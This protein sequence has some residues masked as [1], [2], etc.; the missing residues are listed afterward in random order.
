MAV[1]ALV[2][3][4]AEQFSFEIDTFIQKHSNAFMIV[5]AIIAAT[6]VTVDGI[7]SSGH[8]GGKQN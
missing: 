2:M 4:V 5:M 3:I 7:M 8:K 6:V 1:I